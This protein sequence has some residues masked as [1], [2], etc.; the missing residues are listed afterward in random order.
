MTGYTVSPQI[1]TDG[2][3]EVTITYT[4]GRVTK[5]A[6]ACYGGRYYRLSI[7]ITTKPLKMAYSYLETLLG[8]H[9]G[10]RRYSGRGSSEA[11]SG[12]TY[13]ETAFSTLG[14]AGGGDCVSM[15]GA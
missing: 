1:L 5:T 11:V 8:R 4:E 2:V 12:Y 14:A 15:R 7:A 9:G 13:P 3:T 10:H 6:G